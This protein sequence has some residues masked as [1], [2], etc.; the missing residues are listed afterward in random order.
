[1]YVRNYKHENFV[2]QNSKITIIVSPTA[3]L[4]YKCSF[5]FEIVFGLHSSWV[6]NDSFI[7]VQGDWWEI[8]YVWLEKYI[9]NCTKDAIW[10]RFWH[11]IKYKI[12]QLFLLVFGH[13]RFLVRQKIR[14]FNL[15]KLDIFF[16]KC[17]FSNEGKIFQTR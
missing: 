6:R 15:K 7:L 12:I 14:Q 9:K 3:E 4:I 11:I 2:V 17:L 13:A 10:M 1:M 8:F 16:K 5:S